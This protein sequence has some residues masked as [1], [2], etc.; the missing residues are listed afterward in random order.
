[1][2]TALAEASLGQLTPIFVEKALGDQVAPEL[3]RQHGGVD[4]DPRIA[5]Y[6]AWVGRKL[7]PFSK[8]GQDPHVYKVLRSEKIINAFALGNGNVYVTRGLLNL[9][10]DEAELAEILGHE[11]GHYGLRHIAKQIDRGIG[12]SSLLAVSTAI[13]MSIKGEKLSEKDKERMQA[14]S[15][16]IPTLILNGFGRDQ[17]LEADQHGLDTM[18]RAGYD[19]MGAVSIFQRFQKLE[20]E[21][22]GLDVF[23]RSHPTAK[24]RI[25]DLEARIR[26]RY[27][28]VTGERFADRYQSIVH[29]TS[30][31]SDE[32]RILPGIPDEVLYI[33][34]GIMLAGGVVAVLLSL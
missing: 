31:V 8:R 5:E 22:Q 24:I 26:R 14:A 9:I 10:Q 19:P 3:E 6:V 27:P 13:Y 21:V 33:G 12:T 20:P 7:L 18:V 23:F 4:P 25:S 2:T 32:T 17:E 1:V 11:N 15:E 29:G 28:N 30:S 16:I 34:G